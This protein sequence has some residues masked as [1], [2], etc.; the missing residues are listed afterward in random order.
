MAVTVTKTWQLAKVIL[1][2]ESGK[3][4]TDDYWEIPEDA[5]GPHDTE[6]SRD[7]RRV[8]GGA[9]LVVSQ[10]PWGYPWLVNPL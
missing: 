10:E 2:K 4:Y 9:V 6:R 8:G 3:Y 1:F 5:L 7:F